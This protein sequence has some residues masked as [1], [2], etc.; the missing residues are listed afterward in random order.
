MNRVL[1]RTGVDNQRFIPLSLKDL[2]NDE[3]SSILC[4]I[5]VASFSRIQLVLNISRHS[6]NLIYRLKKKY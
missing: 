4:K 3:F 2:L 6:K 5:K 1:I